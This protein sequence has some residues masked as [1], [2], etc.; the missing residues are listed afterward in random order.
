MGIILNNSLFGM[1]EV[2]NM[3]FWFGAVFGCWFCGTIQGFVDI[4]NEDSRPG[5]WAIITGLGI[6]V[7][8]IIVLTFMT[9]GK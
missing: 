3:E 5:W 1:K 7:V 2:N 9:R 4:K 8:M 6:P